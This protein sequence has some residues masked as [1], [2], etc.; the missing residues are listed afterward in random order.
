MSPIL[1][2]TLNIVELTRVAFSPQENV[3]RVQINS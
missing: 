3:D 1:S 2:V